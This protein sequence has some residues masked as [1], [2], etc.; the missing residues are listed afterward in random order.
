MR[1]YFPDSQ[2]QVDP[3]F[4]FL[5]EEHLPHRIRQRDDRY[6]HEVL[7]VPAYDGVLVS[8]AIVD[9]HIRG[10]GKY[11]GAQRRRLYDLGARAFFRLDTP[12]GPL[13]SIG[14]CGAFNYVEQEE[15]PITVDD[16]IDFYEGCGFDA[17]ISVDH[18]VPAFFSERTP[19]LFTTDEHRLEVARWRKRVDITLQHAEEFRR[20]HRERDCSF[21]PVASAQGWSPSSYARSVEHLQRLG[22][23]RIALGGLVPMKTNQIIESLAAVNDIRLPQTQLHLLGVTRPRELGRFQAFGVASFD[24]TSPFRQAF[25]DDTHNYHWGQG[26]Y[27]TAIRVP[28]LEGNPYLRQM[29]K[30]GKIDQDQARVDE[31]RV[32]LALRRYG[33]GDA[34]LSEVLDSL[35]RYHLLAAKPD[36][37]T[38]M[39][40]DRSEEYARTLDD[41][42]WANCNCGVCAL[43]GIDVVVFR[44]SERNKR[45]GF[46]NVSVFARELRQR[47]IHNDTTN[48]G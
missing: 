3:N 14:D 43:T 22:Y 7:A 46:H 9:G 35:R 48:S 6:A 25:M 28:Q 44:G 42:P 5:R 24:S 33:E 26:R 38:G 41:R 20:R 39:I 12:H 47:I 19:V 4:D 32:L 16:A 37:R 17:G 29:I 11:T 36:P 30:S 13:D 31:R 45:R 1:F 23:T 21:E 15:P 27:Y 40:R 18:L 34:S 2:D 10:S 8:K